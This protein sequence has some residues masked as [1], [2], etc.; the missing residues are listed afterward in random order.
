MYIYNYICMFV[1]VWYQVI[2]QDF[3]RTWMD[4]CHSYGDG[5]E[6]PG[7]EIQARHQWIYPLVMTNIAIENNH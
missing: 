5:H 4:L 1:Q 2:V 3:S 7:D 6:S